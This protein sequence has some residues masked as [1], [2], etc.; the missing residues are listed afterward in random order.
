[1]YRL[2]YNVIGVITLLPVLIIPA[3][4]PGQT[5]YELRGVWLVLA[6]LGQVFAVLVLFMGLFQTD[7]WKFL[8]LRQLI[9]PSGEGDQELVVS[10]FYRCVRHPLYVAGLIFIWL[11]PV[12]TTSLII[13]NLG[14]TL[15]I[16][17]GSIFEERRLLVE[18]GTAYLTYR[19]YVPRLIP[20]IGHCLS[21]QT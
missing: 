12:M 11:M 8:G 14:L 17:I 13:L 15:Y 10:G 16:Y 1:M 2:I 21:K 4:L 6:I 20:R 9:H 18:Y 3:L 5:L 7:P 19:R